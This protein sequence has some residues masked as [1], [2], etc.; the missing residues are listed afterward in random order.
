[1][2]L[3]KRIPN[4]MLQNRVKQ[5]ILETK[6]KKEKLLIEQTLVKKRILMILESEENI[7]NFG[8]LSKL[9]QEKIA[10]K[11]VSEINYLQETNLLN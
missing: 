9:K 2:F 11:L 3:N 7:K 1:M 6:E 5:A 10:F 4:K 8:S